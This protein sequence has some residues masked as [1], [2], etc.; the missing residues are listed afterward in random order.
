MKEQGRTGHGVHKTCHLQQLEAQLACARG[1]EC[2]ENS[3]VTFSPGLRLQ[4]RALLSTCVRVN[5]SPKRVMGQ[6]ASFSI[7]S[8]STSSL[9]DAEQNEMCQVPASRGKAAN[10]LDQFSSPPPSH[11][12]PSSPGTGTATDGA[13]SVWGAAGR[14][15]RT[16][17]HFVSSRREHGQGRGRGRKAGNA[18]T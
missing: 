18:H 6:S 2:M 5:V 10:N 4:S 15:K 12:P 3:L 13:Q 14:D 8:P 16:A 1:K 9:G 11:T 17:P 7:S